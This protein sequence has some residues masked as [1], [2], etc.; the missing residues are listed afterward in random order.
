LLFRFR[1][2]RFR[3]TEGYVDAARVWCL[4]MHVMLGEQVLVTWDEGFCAKN[5][6]Y[7]PLLRLSLADFS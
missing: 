1:I 4:E 5:C 7:L 3:L 2:R 6:F